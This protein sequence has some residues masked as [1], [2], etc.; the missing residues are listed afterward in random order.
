M[1]LA[2]TFLN[3]PLLLPEECDK[4]LERLFAISKPRSA[5]RVFTAKVLA[6]MYSVSERKAAALS[7]QVE[8]PSRGARRKKS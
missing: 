8:T 5:K 2:P 7:K 4:L 1:K 6:E 3:N